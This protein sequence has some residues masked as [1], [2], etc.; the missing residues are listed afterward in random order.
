M[1]RGGEAFRNLAGGI[2]P[3]PPTDRRKLLGFAR[4]D[5]SSIAHGFSHPRAARTNDLARAS[6]VAK[7]GSL[8][9]LTLM[10]L[11]LLAANFAQAESAKQAVAR[12]HAQLSQGDT[13]VETWRQLAHALGE[14]GDIAG[15][16]AALLAG[17]KQ[18]PQSAP[19]LRDL[20]K[21]YID[22]T[23]TTEALPV[24][25][26]ALSRE[27]E[28][29]ETRDAL[30]YVLYQTGDAVR[31]LEVSNRGQPLGP[32]QAEALVEAARFYTEW[33]HQEAAER[34]L[35]K[36][37]E[38]AP[39]SL[40]VSG[41]LLR[42]SGPSAERSATPPQTNSSPGAEESTARSPGVRAPQETSGPLVGRDP[43]QAVVVG[44]ACAGALVVLAAL[45][46]FFVF[47]RGS[48]DLAVTI[49]YPQERKG[50]FSPPTPEAALRGSPPN[51]L[52]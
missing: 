32:A 47:L 51:S 18:D 44:L 34:A 49:D 39:N 6:C 1:R 33:G 35:A 12:L 10:A 4:L 29:Q 25:E 27:P 23:R 16:E 22:T 17:L 38:L 50:S 26:Q 21:L 52:R 41:A 20:G 2:H 15:A 19:A 13:S 37:Q 30:S 8:A 3:Q 5:G 36:A 24:L 9:A 40:A 46:I 43:P 7:G 28:D 45:R 31:S 42:R 48:G 14:T 11:L